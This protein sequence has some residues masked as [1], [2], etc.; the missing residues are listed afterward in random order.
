MS[1]IVEFLPLQINANVFQHLLG[2]IWSYWR[3]SAY[4][5]EITKLQ[6]NAQFF[7]NFL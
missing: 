7:W 6:M 4:M 5:Q 1:Y 3:I 2:I